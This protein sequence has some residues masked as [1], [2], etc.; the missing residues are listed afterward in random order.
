MR[1]L[2]EQAVL[3]LAQPCEIQLSLFPDFVCKAD[4][5]AL[6]FEDGLY[7]LV[8][9]EAELNPAQRDAVQHLDDLLRSMSGK[10]NFGLWTESALRG[11]PA[12]ERVRLEARVVLAA[13]GWEDR[14]LLPSPAVYIPSRR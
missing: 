8:G 13:F 14:P 4:E 7:E 6:N 12:W 1:N 3:A 5:L 2:L 11:H 9:H 10:Q